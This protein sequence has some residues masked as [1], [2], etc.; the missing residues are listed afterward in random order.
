MPVG[1]TLE[2]AADNRLWHVKDRG[3]RRPGQPAFA[4]HRHRGSGGGR[5]R[6]GRERAARASLAGG[7]FTS[8][9]VHGPLRLAGRRPV[10]G[11]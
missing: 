5:R 4:A 7:P 6:N 1:N 2:G 10:H 8:R 9:A 11:F 3:V